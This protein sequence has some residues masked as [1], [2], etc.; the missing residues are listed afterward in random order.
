[1]GLYVDDI[2]EMLKIQKDQLQPMEWHMLLNT[3]IHDLLGVKAINEDSIKTFRDELE[4]LTV[5][6]LD[7]Q[8]QINSKYENI[9]N[10]ILAL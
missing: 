7:L 8:K 1:M 3:T 10:K 4:K 2:K 5:Q 6:V 9:Y